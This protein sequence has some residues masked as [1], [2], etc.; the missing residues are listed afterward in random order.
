MRAAVP[1]PVAAPVSAPQREP[2]A[3]LARGAVAERPP[4]RAEAALALPRVLAL[5]RS[6]PEAHLP[7]P[8]SAAEVA[9]AVGSRPAPGPRPAGAAARAGLAA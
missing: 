8:G 6:G 4:G 9:A 5:A 3:L 7:R 1:P 2:A